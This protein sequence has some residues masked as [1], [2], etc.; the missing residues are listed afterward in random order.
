MEVQRN[1][2]PNHKGKEVA[3][4]VIC[5]D[6]REDEEERPA[7]SVVAITILQKSSQF[8]NLFNQLELIA[9]EQRIATEVLV[10]IAS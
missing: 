4:V 1:S 6:S 3:A 5:V 2:F 10:S 8:K 9:N 7:L